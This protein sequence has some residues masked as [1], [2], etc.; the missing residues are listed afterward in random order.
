M[1]GGV[2]NGA[3][4]RRPSRSGRPPR[5][6]EIGPSVKRVLIRGVPGVDRPPPPPPPLQLVPRACPGRARGSLTDSRLSRRLPSKVR[7]RVRSGR[8]I[9]GPDSPTKRK[10]VC[11]SSPSRG[12]INK[13][14]TKFYCRSSRRVCSFAAQLGIPDERFVRGQQRRAALAPFNEAIKIIE[15]IICLRK[16]WPGPFTA[17]GNWIPS[18]ENASPRLRFSVPRLL[19]GFGFEWRGGFPVELRRI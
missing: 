7:C 1:R 19:R 15:S 2:V 18:R 11:C 10:R 3:A 9:P 6:Q 16:S 8:Y 5:I 12:S 4:S 13:F 17:T 14:R